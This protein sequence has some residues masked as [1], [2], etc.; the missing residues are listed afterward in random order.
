MSETVTPGIDL[1]AA[2]PPKRPRRPETR[3]R[4]VGA[5][6]ELMRRQGYNATG[7]KQIVAAAQAPFGSI[8]HHFPGGKEQLGAESIRASGKLYEQLIPAI[9]DPAPDLPAA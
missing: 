9:F 8:Y 6:A 2:T 1:N 4:I 7:I 3:E 5:S